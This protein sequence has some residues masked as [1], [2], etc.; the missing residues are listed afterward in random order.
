M[1]EQLNCGHPTV[2]TLVLVCTPPLLLL[3]LLLPRRLTFCK[4][5]SV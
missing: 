1:K 5:L 4:L 3:L 2:I